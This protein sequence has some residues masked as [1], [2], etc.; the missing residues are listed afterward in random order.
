MQNRTNGVRSDKGMEMKKIILIKIVVG[1]ITFLIFTF[2][3]VLRNN[4]KGQEFNIPFY[5]LLFPF[6][7]FVIYGGL[8]SLFADKVTERWKRFPWLVS[9]LL[10]LLGGAIF[11]FVLSLVIN[12]SQTIEQPK[13]GYDT[14]LLPLGLISSAVYWTVNILIYP[15]FKYK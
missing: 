2:Y 15:F 12:L 11:P 3:L 5:I 9:L 1:T 8:I 10:H 13:I 7:M 4:I 14:G 6:F